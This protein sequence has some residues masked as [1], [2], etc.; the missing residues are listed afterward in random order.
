MS[1]AFAS[2]QLVCRP[3][4]ARDTQDILEFTKFIWGGDDYISYVWNDWL[5]DPQ[6]LLAVAELGGR[7]VAMS[8]I[9]L[10]SKGQW[11]LEGFRVDPNFQGRKVGS[12]IH[13]YVDQWWLEHGEGAV[14]LM[15]S[16]MRVQ[17]HHLCDRLGYQK[18]SE[19]SSCI[20]QSIGE[21]TDHFQLVSS[22]DAKSALGFALKSDTLNLLSGLMDLGWQHAAPD[23]L[24]LAKLIEER[25]AYWWRGRDGLLLLWNEVD[26]MGNKVFGLGLPACGIENLPDLLTDARGLAGKMNYQSAVW[27][28]PVNQPQVVSALEKA[29]FMNDWEN[30]A[31]LY[32]KRHPRRP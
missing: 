18:I 21:K 24:L 16:S 7:A 9:S 31:Y 14:R 23:E 3:A 10:A 1:H 29:G 26:E 2:P 27:M 17:V 8:K 19:I 4:L 25:N 22:T 5:A 11:W 20:A 12:R 6:G 13:E 32:Q 15:T 30:S 28:A